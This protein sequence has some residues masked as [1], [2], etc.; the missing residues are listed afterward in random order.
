M[1]GFTTANQA[2]LDNASAIVVAVNDLTGR[3]N[4]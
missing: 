3:G 2:D 1:A 4:S